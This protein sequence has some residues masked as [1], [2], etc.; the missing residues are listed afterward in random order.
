MPLVPAAFLVLYWNST[1]LVVKENVLM[2]SP[3][4]PFQTSV[5]SLSARGGATFP[6]GHTFAV[7]AEAAITTRVR[8]Q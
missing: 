7:F 5:A 1:K 3:T 8:Y 2:S 4:A 6:S